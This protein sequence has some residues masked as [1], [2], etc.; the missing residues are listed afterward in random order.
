MTFTGLP[1][2]LRTSLETADE[3]SEGGSDDK[4]SGDGAKGGTKTNDDG[5]GKD[6]DESKG[7]TDGGTK[8]DQTGESPKPFTLDGKEYDEKALEGIVRENQN[9]ENW[10]K[11]NTEN[12]Q[13]NADRA[14]AMD[15]VLE[16]VEKITSDEDA[17]EVLQDYGY[18]LSKE[19]IQQVRKAA[20]EAGPAKPKE[21]TGTQDA[22]G[23]EVGKLKER[24]DQMEN[25][26]Q[27]ERDLQTFVTKDDDCRK[28]FDTTEKVEGFL[29]FMADNGL[30]D[31][32]KAFGLYTA[33]QRAETAEKALEEAGGGKRSPNAPLG[34]GAREI[35]TDFKPVTGDFGYDAAGEASRKRLGI[36]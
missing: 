22:T 25:E 30:T 19:D 28:A 33:E 21:E 1:D 20:A 15:K 6:G 9:N 7:G 8:G 3:Q 32:D 2:D 29:K 14:K 35:K 10:N 13:A 36:D 5:K 18:K 31:M 34:K 12:A 26:R 17:V 27:F 24:L 4:G 23:D 16:V 11:T